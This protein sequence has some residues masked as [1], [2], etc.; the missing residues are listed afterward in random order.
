MT[1]QE[2][3]A[4]AAGG[5]RLLDGA[6]GT[7]MA[8][9]GLPRGDC[10]EAWICAHPQGLIDLQRAYVEA[11][12]EIVYAPT[13]G[14][15]RE[16][17]SRFGLAQELV[18]MNA[19]L[20]ELSKQAAQ[21]RAM[22]AGDMTTTGRPLTDEPGEYE[23]RIELYREQALALVQ[24]GVDLFAVETMMGVSET[25]AALEAIR[26]V[27]DLPVLCTL[28]LQSDGKAYFDGC[29]E[30]AAVA[31]EAL[32]ADAVG[33]NCASGPDQ[34]QSV[35]AALRRS[36]GLPIVAKPNAG[37]PVIDEMTGQACYSMDETAF[38]SHMERLKQAGATILGGCCGTTPAYIRALRKRLTA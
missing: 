2:F 15:N 27:S 29:A 23:A 19:T 1:R 36:C 4:W 20:V 6:T 24:S 13:F 38:A 32:G 7:N 12:S 33:V 3:A 35:V 16:A 11:G 21:G 5:V 28:S 26:S 37:L 10:T 8:K 22:V 30:E 14:A 34:L 18:Q 17:L 31:L 9:M 25:M